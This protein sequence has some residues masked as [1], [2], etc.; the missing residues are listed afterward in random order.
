MT[1]TAVYIYIDYLARNLQSV[2]ELLLLCVVSV[3]RGVFLRKDSLQVAV[4]TDLLAELVL[5]KE[6]P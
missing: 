3:A 2:V 4:K 5:R 1:S 6:K